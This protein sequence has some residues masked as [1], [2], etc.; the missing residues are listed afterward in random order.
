MSNI[1]THIAA[2][3]VGGWFGL[4]IAALCAAAGRDRDGME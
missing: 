4:F 2:F 3:V 1:I